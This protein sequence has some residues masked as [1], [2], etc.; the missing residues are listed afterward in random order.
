M[1]AQLNSLL[2]IKREERCPICGEVIRG[3]GVMR[4]GNRF[5]CKWHADFYRPPPLWWR[6]WRW[7][8]DAGGGGGAG[9]CP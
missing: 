5:C 3:E 2:N 8:D 9:C 1:F 4:H 6:R 7:P